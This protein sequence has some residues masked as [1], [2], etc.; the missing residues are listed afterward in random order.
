MALI[1]SGITD[2]AAEELG[3]T[4][5]S[6][7]ESVRSDLHASADYRKQVGAAMVAAAWQRARQEAING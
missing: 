7:L 4:V 1:G 2:I 5:A 3:Q 6:A